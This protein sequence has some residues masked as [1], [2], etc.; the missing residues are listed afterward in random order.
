LASSKSGESA[1]IE[2]II[3]IKHNNVGS[4]EWVDDGRKDGPE[5]EKKKRKN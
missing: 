4:G 1:G 2:E 5:R 3:S